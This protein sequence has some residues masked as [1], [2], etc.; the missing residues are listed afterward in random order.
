MMDFKR[1]KNLLIED[2]NYSENGAASVTE[3][4]LASKDEIK[5]AIEQ[6]FI[7][8]EI[9]TLEVE[10]I[11]V[12]HLIDRYQMNPI[13]ALL[14]LDWLAREPEKAKDMLRKGYDRPLFK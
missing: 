9:P 4:I 1:I 13:A 8:R 7:N 3:K 11:N 14:T 6:Y 12:Q 2:F 10:M 5:Q